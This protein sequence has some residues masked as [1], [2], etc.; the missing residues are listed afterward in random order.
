MPR[1]TLTGRGMTD[2]PADY[3]G[4]PRE[5]FE[6][7]LK[8]W[9]PSQPDDGRSLPKSE[10]SWRRSLIEL[11]R[12]RLQPEGSPLR[13][14]PEW[15]YENR[16]ADIGIE[17]PKF[18]GRATDFVEVKQGLNRM[19]AHDLIAEIETLKGTNHWTFG[20]ICGSEDNVEPGYIDRLKK[21]WTFPRW[22]GP[23]PPLIAVYWKQVE[24]R[25]DHRVRR[26][27]VSTGP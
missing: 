15:G 21:Q 8:A 9:E 23:Q 2:W 16:R 11:L 24:G 5:V 25:A 18:L 10:S 27:V 7:L 12:R 26:I 13:I 19:K 3:K 6:K 22:G 14:A 20:V 4:N 1:T 17:R